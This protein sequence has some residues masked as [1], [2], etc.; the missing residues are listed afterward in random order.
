MRLP[1]ALALAAG[2]V[3]QSGATSSMK[4]YDY[5]G[6]EVA[7]WKGTR[8]VILLP[9]L[10]ESKVGQASLAAK[11]TAI[12]RLAF[13]HSGRFELV[14]IHDFNPTV[15]R[16]L[17]EGIL[18]EAEVQKA[19][20]DPT[21]ESVPKIAGLLGVDYVAEVKV[22]DYKPAT[23]ATALEIILEGALI[24]TRT[25][26][27]AP[28]EPGRPI[29]GRSLTNPLGANPK[30]LETEALSVAC[31]HLVGVFAGDQV[32][33][34]PEELLPPPP[35]EPEPTTE[36][37]QPPAPAPPDTAAAVPG[38]ET[39]PAADPGEQAEK[40]REPRGLDVQLPVEWFYYLLSAVIVAF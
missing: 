2:F 12:M 5:P 15:Q 1:V 24:D 36:A 16:G 14:A 3:F 26:E 8:S 18:A 20:D 31:N 25:G 4:I 39:P 32:P 38:G 11:T 28:L 27:D 19:M 9:V 37:A 22:K 35:P 29:W 7:R 30:R 10:N 6:D 23:E 33:P 40:P 13:V 17:T 34:T 21:R